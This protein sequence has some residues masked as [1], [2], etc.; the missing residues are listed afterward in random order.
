MPS[1]RTYLCRYFGNRLSGQGGKEICSVVEHP[2]LNV[3][4]I[5]LL[6]LLLF[7]L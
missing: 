7:G 3:G 5:A 4:D 6:N 1:G 2:V